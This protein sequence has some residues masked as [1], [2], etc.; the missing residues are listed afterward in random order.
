MKRTPNPYI[1]RIIAIVFLVMP[2]FVAFSNA[3]GT[4]VFFRNLTVKSPDGRY[5]LEAKSPDNAGKER[6]PFASNFTYTLYETDSERIIWTRKQPSDEYAPSSIFLHNDLWVVIR[7]GQDDLVGLQPITAKRVIKLRILDE[8][9]DIEHDRYVM[10]TSAGPM[11]SGG[12][13]WFFLEHDGDMHFVIRTFWNRLIIV[14][15]TDGIKVSKPDEELLKACEVSDREFVLKELD[16]AKERIKSN[17][18][19]RINY[20]LIKVL[21]VIDLAGRSSIPEAMSLLREL[22]EYDY[23]RLVNARSNIDENYKD[24]EINPFNRSTAP[25]RSAV[26]RAL[27]KLKE[28]PRELPCTYFR[29]VLHEG[30]GE[31]VVIPKLPTLRAERIYLV[32]LSTKPIDVLRAIGAPDKINFQQEAWE[33]YMDTDQPFTFRVYWRDRSIV[34]RCKKITPAIWK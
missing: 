21:E 28:K 3:Y 10:E 14:N 5:R 32:M 30:V 9:P 19:E 12:S 4:D 8:I 29:Y 26:H 31:I 34:D 7:T 33:Y 6:R 22:E 25:I 2:L 15:L 11:W 1:K 16:G 20:A 27:R 17:E 18:G 13:R 23:V 24:G